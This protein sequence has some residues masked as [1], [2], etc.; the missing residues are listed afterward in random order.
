MQGKNIV[1]A[2][3][4]GF[5][6]MQMAARWAQ[7]NKVT[8]LTRN[9]GTAVNNTYGTGT[10]VAGISY[11]QWDGKTLGPWVSALEGCDLL[12][13]LAGRTVNCRYNARNKAE[14]MNSRVD[15]TKVL[16]QAV[17]QL[18]QPP[19]L[20]VNS[21]SA[22]IYRHAEDRPQDEFTGEMGNGFSVQV[23]KAW[24]SAFNNLELPQIRKVVLRMAI[25]LG[26]GGVLVPYSWLARLGIGGKHGN[27][28]QMFSWLHI[29]DLCRMMEWLYEHND[30]QGTFNASAPGPL[31]N[32]EFMRLLR[33]HYKMPV[34]IPAPAWLLEIGA[35]IQRTETELLLK[36]RWVLPTRLVQQGF[37]FNYPDLGFA[38]KD[39]L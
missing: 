5:I 6:G 33:T 36:S 18:Q 17:L 37:R 14:I 35:L 1:I 9:T 13:N 30:Q 34:G 39:L 29:D 12:I 24:E 10:A 8:I 2:G 25:I 38:I 20:W 3:G 15:A 31:P 32:A 28:R 4:T 11:V 27:G 7:A 22:T 21:A 16:G 26:K 23:C 19:A